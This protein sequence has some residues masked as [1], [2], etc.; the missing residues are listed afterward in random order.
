MIPDNA[1]LIH[2]FTPPTRQQISLFFLP[3]HNKNESKAGNET[4]TRAQKRP[5]GT[6]K[7]ERKGKDRHQPT[8]INR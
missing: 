7:K 4:T 1:S 3:S 5:K 6:K 2:V 8:Y